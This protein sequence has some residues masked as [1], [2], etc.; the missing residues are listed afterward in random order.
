VYEVL[1]AAKAGPTDGSVPGEWAVNFNPL[2][3]PTEA[4]QAANR[5]LIGETDAIY[6]A[7]QVYTP[8]HV[9]ESRFGDKGYQTELLPVTVDDTDEGFAALERAR[10]ELAAPTELP[11]VEPDVEPTE[12]EP[13][14]EADI[15]PGTGPAATA[16][17]AAGVDVQKTA[18]NGAQVTA[19]AGL[20]A[21]VAEGALPRDAVLG[22]LQVFFNLS[23]DEAADIMGTVGTTF[24]PDEPEDEQVDEPAAEPLPPVAE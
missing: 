5:K 23:T 21:S 6:I 2:D 16:A 15:E 9:A 24:V 4:E 18:L 20:V 1:F 13:L 17:T 3:E 10:A 22:M 11:D 12:D 19:A 7:A 14:A 8:E